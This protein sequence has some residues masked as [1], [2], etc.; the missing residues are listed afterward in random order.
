[1]ISLRTRVDSK[2]SGTGGY[3]RVVA[4]STPGVSGRED[5]N[6]GIRMAKS[7]S[8]IEASMTNLGRMR[9]K[10]GIVNGVIN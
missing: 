8:R 5:L 3:R 9:L 10:L 2:E 7:L 4:D 1:M 6:L